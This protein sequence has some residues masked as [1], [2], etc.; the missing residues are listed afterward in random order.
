MDR[1]GPRPLRL[2]GGYD[3]QCFSKQ[4]DEEFW[5]CFLTTCVRLRFS[6]CFAAS[7]AIIAAAAYNPEGETKHHCTTLWMVHP[8]IPLQ[9]HIFTFLIQHWPTN[10]YTITF[11][12]QSSTKL[13]TY[14]N[15]T[16]LS[17]LRSLD[18]LHLFHQCCLVS[19]FSLSP[20]MALEE[21]AWPSPH[22]QYD[23]HPHIHATQVRDTHHVQ[24]S[25][26][27]ICLNKNYVLFY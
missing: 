5:A 4:L 20:L 13:K 11:D 19:S 27:S 14:L 25:S 23:S 12:R 17:F 24:T 16:K 15:W 1:Y 10:N 18:S 9:Y 21:S 6:S 3:R 26:L 22:S 8:I 7:C 2:V